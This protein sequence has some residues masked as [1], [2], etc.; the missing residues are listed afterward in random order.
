MFPVIDNKVRINR[1]IGRQELVV[2]DSFP[3]LTPLLTHTHTTHTH[4]H[5]HSITFL[6]DNLGFA[7]IC[8]TSPCFD[9]DLFRTLLSY[10]IHFSS[11]VMSRFKNASVSFR[12][13]NDSQMEIRSIKF[14][15]VKSYGTRTSNFFLYPAFSGLKLFC[16]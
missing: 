12:F 6:G 2:N 4:I 5:T 1:L 13:S 9:H 15:I 10:V 16:D 11:P 8:G 3:I 7:I 14:F